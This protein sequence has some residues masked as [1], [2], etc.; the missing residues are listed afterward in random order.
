M[1]RCSRCGETK[2]EA[3][4]N[5][6]K[7]RSSGFQGYCKSCSSSYQ[8]DPAYRKRNLERRR[9]RYRENPEKHIADYQAR[10]AADPARVALIQRRSWIKRKYGITL[11]QYDEMLASQGGVCGLC[12]G[13]PTRINLAVDHD[14]ITGEVR[15]LL[16]DLCNKGL[17][18]LKD[19][20]VLLRRAAEYVE[21][22]RGE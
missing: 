21:K 20:P 8:Q 22:F 1:R 18:C 16:C 3:E 10:R 6:S 7:T 9:E 19:D 17:G 14:H 15:M 11:E 12:G 13:P 5:R 4:F 2:L